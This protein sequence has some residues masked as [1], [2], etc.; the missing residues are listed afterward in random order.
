MHGDCSTINILE[1]YK[2]SIIRVFIH[3][4][5]NI[6][7]TIDRVVFTRYLYTYIYKNMNDTLEF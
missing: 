7:C 6:S 5:I 4:F 2:D 1:F 3:Y